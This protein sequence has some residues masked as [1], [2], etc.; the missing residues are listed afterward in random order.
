MNSHHPRSWVVEGRTEG[1]EF[2]TIDEE[3]DSAF[4]NG[5]SL[6]H[7]FAL[8]LPSSKEFKYIRMRL[9]GPNWAKDDFLIFDSFEIYGRLI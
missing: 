5:V 1:G 7:T 2:E 4:L 9:T 8:S 6:V 3:A